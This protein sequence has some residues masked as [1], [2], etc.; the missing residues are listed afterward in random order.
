MNLNKLMLMSICLLCATNLLAQSVTLD[1]PHFAGQEWYMTA[2]RGDGK[3]TITTG[4]LDEQGK[5]K[6]ILPEKYK[7]HRG[8]TQ[9]LLRKGGGLDIIIAGGENVSVSCLEAQPSEESIKYT[10]SSEN[11]YLI[12][13][14]ARQQRILA[15]VDAMR[16]SA[17]VYKD[18]NELLPVLKKELNKQEQVYNRLQDE[19]AIN[20]MYAARFAQI[21]DITRGLPPTLSGNEDTGVVLK[22]FILNNL[23]IYSLYTSGHWQAVIGQWLDW[24]AYHPENEA[25]LIEDYRVLKKRITNKEIIDAFENTVQKSLHGKKRSDL[26]LLTQQHKA[27][28]LVQ[29]KL[30]NKKTILVFYESGCGSC[31]A[32]MAKLSEQYYDIQKKGYEVISISADSDKDI[33]ERTANIYPW[34]DKHCDFQGFAGKDFINYGVM[35][36]PTFYLIDEKG[37]IKGIYA[38][39]DDMKL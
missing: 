23:D 16:M 27:P 29:G 11:T 10:Q 22:D 5:T 34:K 4:K 6:I 28:V 3:D 25:L 20:P 30:P 32:Q 38:Q 31:T 14:Y 19:T 39:V 33:Y 35:G 1:F 26:A 21:V 18:D 8:M 15:K 13:R 7:N 37:I 12:D 2:F 9:W 36:T 17:E 24:Y